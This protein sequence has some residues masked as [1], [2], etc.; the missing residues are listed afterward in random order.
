MSAD[1]KERFG[2]KGTVHLVLRD[3]YG[4]IKQEQ[5]INN[6]VVNSGFAYVASRM[7]DATATA[8]SHMAIGSGTT[9]VA[10]SQTA[11]V[12][13][14]GRVTL[15]STTLVTTTVS[16]DSIRY[17]ATFPAGTGTGACTELGMLNNGTGGTMLAR[18]VFAVMNKGSGDSITAT[19]TIA[20]S[21]A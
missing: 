21:A 3:M 1:I 8:M 9:A 15:T 2:L 14:L 18:V 10:G 11:L 17:I 13:E 19:W 12:A 7:K 4:N 5:T 16:N 6:A 20:S